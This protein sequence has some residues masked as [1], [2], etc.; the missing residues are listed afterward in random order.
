MDL[1]AVRTFIVG[2][3]ILAA[4]LSSVWGAVLVDLLAFRGSKDPGGFFQTFS[5]K[6]A[7]WRYLQAFVGGF[8]GNLA[9]TGAIGAAGAVTALIVWGPL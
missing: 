8:V 4:S 3:P 9:V 6:V 2:H 1:D 5:F 7:G